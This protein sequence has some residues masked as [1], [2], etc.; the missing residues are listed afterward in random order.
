[1]RHVRSLGFD[2]LESRKLMTKVHPAAAHIDPFPPASSTPPTAAEVA[3]PQTLTLQGT[4]TANTKAARIITDDFGD[5][6]T[7]TP[8]S[9]VLAGIGLVHGT[10]DES[11]DEAQ[12]YL[13]PDSIQLHNSKGSFVIGFDATSL[14]QS[15]QTSQGTVYPGAGLQLDNG[16]GIYANATASGYVQE[17]TNARQTVIEGL[18]LSGNTSS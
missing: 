2:D 11:A 17:V 15:V 13:G 14:G 5:Q 16:T 10:W 3:A 18:T 12:Q 9:G 4:L 7:A 6:T 8:V 1:M